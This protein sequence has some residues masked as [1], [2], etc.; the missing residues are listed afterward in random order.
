MVAASSSRGTLILFLV[1]VGILVAALAFFQRVT[2]TGKINCAYASWKTARYGECSSVC[3]GVQF[4]TLSVVQ[5]AMNGGKE[6]DPLQAIRSQSC[7]IDVACNQSCIPGDPS[8]IPWTACPMCISTNI[9][10]VQ[11]KIIPPLQPATNGGT[12][13]RLDDVLQTRPCDGFIPACPPSVDCVLSPYASTS[14][15]ATCGSGTYNILQSISQFP[16]GDGL[17]CNPAFLT[18]QQSCY[19]DCHCNEFTGPFTTCNA[20][21]GMGIQAR[22]QGGQPSPCLSVETQSCLITECENTTCFPPSVEYIQALC[23]LSCSGYALPEFADGVCSTSAMMATICSAQGSFNPCA[24]PQN[25]SLS[26]WSA[27]SQCSIPMCSTANQGGGTRTSVRTIVA[28]AVGGGVQCMDEVLMI[29]QPCNAWIP[30]PYEAYNTVTSTYTSS[31]SAAACTASK[32][33]EYS[34]YYSVS[35]CSAPCQGT[36]SITYF[37]SVTQLPDSPFAGV[38]CNLLPS[39]LTSYSLCINATAC[40][41]CVWYSPDDDPSFFFECEYGDNGWKSEFVSLASY[42]N[43]VDCFTTGTTCTFDDTTKTIGT[44]TYTNGKANGVYRTETCKAYG[45]PCSGYSKCPAP[46]NLVCNGEG[47]PV[48]LGGT[49]TCECYDGWSGAG[50][51]TFFGIQCPIGSNTQP[52]SGVGECNIVTGTCTCPNGD[53][54]LNCSAQALAWCWVY[55]DYVMDPCALSDFTWPLRKMMGAFPILD[56]TYGSFST[57]NCTDLASEWGVNDVSKVVFTTPAPLLSSTP[58]IVA[59]CTMQTARFATQIRPDPPATLFHEWRTYCDM[60]VDDGILGNFADTSQFVH[61]VVPGS[62]PSRCDSLFTQS[63]ISNAHDVQQNV[64]QIDTSDTPAY[65]SMYSLS[66]QTYALPM[67]GGS[68]A[69]STNNNL[70]FQVATYIERITYPPIG[71]VALPG[72][73]NT[74]NFY[75][76]VASGFYSFSVPIAYAPT[77]MVDYPLPPLFGCYVYNHQVFGNNDLYNVMCDSATNARFLYDPVGYPGMYMT[78]P[79]SLT[80]ASIQDGAVT[81]THSMPVYGYWQPTDAGSAPDFGALRF[82]PVVPNTP[83]PTLS[84]G[85]PFTFSRDV[86]SVYTVSSGEVVDG[87]LCTSGANGVYIYPNGPKNSGLNGPFIFICDDTLGPV[88]GSTLRNFTATLHW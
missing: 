78:G 75:T 52:C 71:F 77:V 13:C 53:R 20:A 87:E 31:V 66:S 11:W 64:V 24:E 33:C 23:V 12:D 38:Q 35:G 7:N 34:A 26:A 81:L 17:A 73:Q 3:H 1:V 30:I 45:A 43:T 5:E 46:R 14:C 55:A 9:Y 21:C 18:L 57:Q 8:R 37:R 86:S 41:P 62:F 63:F 51:D 76:H 22:Y 85:T 44:V 29:T 67:Q 59:T 47:V 61:R 83:L 58:P 72:I 16:Q 88:W 19:V 25:C 79:A 15:N 10:P 54:T 42:S 69:T 2:V 39:N 6:C 50:C 4:A 49:C 84:V 82:Q 32:N 27:Y 68:F 70:L 56:S 28:N 60:H 48:T 80:L 40:T 36:G 74:M 65:M